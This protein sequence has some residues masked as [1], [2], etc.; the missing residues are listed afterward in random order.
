MERPQ[1]RKELFDITLCIE[2]LLHFI[3]KG[4]PLN[5]AERELI[6]RLADALRDGA[7]VN[8]HAA[9]KQSC[10]SSQTSEASL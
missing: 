2:T 9:G 6:G 4:S 10:A 7:H 5:S 1:V 8:R 3:D